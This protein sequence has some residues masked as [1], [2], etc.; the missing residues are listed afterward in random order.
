[1]SEGGEPQTRHGVSRH[2]IR[3]EETLAILVAT[4]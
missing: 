3:N 1:M 4:K 2:S